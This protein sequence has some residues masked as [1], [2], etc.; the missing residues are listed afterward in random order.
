LRLLGCQRLWVAAVLV[1]LLAGGF[2]LAWPHWSAWY[3]FRAAR[4]ALER[5]HNPQAIRH[6]QACLRVWPGDADVLLLAARAARRARAYDEADRSLEK[7][8][9]ARGLDERGSFEQLLLAVERNGEE[10][11]INQCRRLV[12]EDHPQ[13]PLI[14]EAL[15]RGYMRHYRLPEARVCLD[16]WLKRQPDNPQALCMKG[17]YHLDYERAPDRAVATYRRALEIDP[18]HEEA[19][20][21]LAIVL[22]Q[23]KTFGEAA[24]HLERLRRSQPDNLRVQVGLA[25][26][27]YSLGDRDEAVRLVDAV[28]ARQPEFAPALALRGRLALEAGEHEQAE[29]WLRQAV[30]GDPRDHQARYNLILV[31][32]HNGNDA[33]AQRHEQWIKQREKDL[34]RFHEI[35]TRDMAVRPHDPALHT[36]L[37]ELLL[38]SGHREE[39]LRWLHSALQQDPQYA[40]ARRALAEQHARQAK[41]QQAQE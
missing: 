12:E 13:A 34:K 25:E 16:F 18:D 5:Y 21:G 41:E 6:L 31:L 10:H 38:R 14:L 26:A 4:A 28:L 23:A 15:A 19:S 37:G 30:R 35:V 27:R 7:Y 36:T 22:L 29:T 17:Q 11:V 20:M 24:E 33:E 1:G 8:Q 32:H 2:A 39:G 9:Q 3:H 40:P